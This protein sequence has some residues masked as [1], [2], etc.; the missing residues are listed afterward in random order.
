MPSSNVI[1]PYP[2]EDEN[3]Y[4]DDPV[5]QDLLALHV[6]EPT[7]GQAEPRL[8]ALGDIAPTKLD[9]WARKAD[10]HRP[11]LNRRSPTGERVDEVEFHPSYR[12]LQRAAREHETFTL[13]W[14][15]IDGDP[16]PRE[17]GLA[18]GYLYAQ[19]EAGYYCPACMTDGAAFVVD[20]HAPDPVRDRYLDRL[21]TADPD[22]GIEGAMYLTEKAGGSDVG[23]ATRTTAEGPD[24][25]GTWRL[26][27]EKWFASNCTAEVALALARMPDADPDSGTEGLGLFVVSRHLP[28]GTRNPG[29][30]IER[31]KDKLGV[32]SMPTGEVVLD[33]AHA[34][35]VAPAGR[36]FKAMAEMVNLS[37]LYNAV[38]SV[39]VAQRALREGRRAGRTRKSWDKHL[40]DH[41]LFLRDLVE[42]T[43]DVEG[44][45][46]FVLD[47]AT[48]FDDWARDDGQRA[49]LRVLT[50]CAKAATGKLAVRAASEGCE[51]LGGNGYI[52]DYVTPRLL[53][54]AQVL[55]IWEGTTNIQG[56]D[57]LRAIEHEQ[58]L[59]AFS[60]HVR[61][62]LSR[63]DDPAIGDTRQ[64]VENRLDA[65]EARAKRLA[66]EDRETIEAHALDLL[67]DA[68][69]A[70]AT[71]LLAWRASERPDDRS[72]DVAEVYARR[73][74][75]DEVSNR[76]QAVRDALGATGQRIAFPN[77]HA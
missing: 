18:L 75:A 46:A 49:L 73:H 61:E 77:E 55:P 65:L 15:T 41:P 58:A 33:D 12:K 19:A 52:E 21:T 76:R 43:V 63:A 25:Q 34:E 54:D 16:A 68:F 62:R 4:T 42:L 3:W 24:E 51:L 69:H 26:T 60:R 66:G 20:R 57:L 59:P 36:G 14:R 6:D 5:L 67:Q 22:E 30:R 40:C 70:H 50:P 31:L 2:A 27:G 53:R 48:V 32:A 64:R 47:T 13:P 29:L 35:L 38:A 7:M 39:A 72:L 11:K 9:R 56:L 10:E 23:G 28:D 44:A 1:D 37:R 74:L 17:V 71:A 45:L 8:E